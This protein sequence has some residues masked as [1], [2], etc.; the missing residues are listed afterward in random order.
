MLPRHLWNVNVRKQAINNKSQ[1]SSA[2][3]LRCGGDIQN[4]IKK[5]L[6]L[7]L[8]GN[9]LEIGKYLAKLQAKR[10]SLEH[11]LRLLWA[12]YNCDT[13]TIRVRFEYDSSAIRARFEHDTT[14]YEELCA[15]E[16]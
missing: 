3:Y 9:F 16:Q 13:S 12:Y 11:L 7:Y 4:E 6:L 2:A 8:S 5:G 10:G 1:G 15:F 14:S